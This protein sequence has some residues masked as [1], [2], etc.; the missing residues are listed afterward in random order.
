MEIQQNQ[1]HTHIVFGTVKIAINFK[2]DIPTNKVGNT[3][4]IFFCEIMAQ[5]L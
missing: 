4:K 3:V 2:T 1:L 5:Q